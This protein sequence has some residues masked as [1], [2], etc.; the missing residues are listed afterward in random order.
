MHRYGWRTLVAGGLR[1]RAFTSPLRSGRQQQQKIVVGA[2]AT[3]TRDVS[4]S[5]SGT[6]PTRHS[7]KG[8]PPICKDPVE[9]Q[10]LTQQVLETPLG[11]LF[12]QHRN[13]KTNS[14][15][16]SAPKSIPSL[17]QDRDE[18]YAVAYESTQ[19]LEYLLRGYNHQI[20]GSL[21][22]GPNNDDVS[23]EGASA[24]IAT[25]V[26][27]MER[28][29]EEGHTYMKLRYEA[30]SFRAGSTSTNT[31]ALV[32]TVSSL[33][34]RKGQNNIDDE[35]SSSSSSSSSSEEDEDFSFEGDDDE[36]IQ[37]GSSTFGEVE[38][39]FSSVVQHERHL[40]GSQLE[41]HISDFALPGVTTV[42]YDSLLDAMASATE[43][44]LNDNSEKA[45]DPSSI[46]YEIDPEDFYDLTQDAL[47]SH[48]LN[49]QS[50][51]S[52][53]GAFFPYTVPT[54]V[55][56]NASLR[57]IGN[58]CL[59]GSMGGSNQLLID[60]GLACGFG[61][62]NQLTHNTQRLPKRNAASI[63]H[64][65]NI[66]KACFPPSRTRGNMTVTLWHQ[67]SQ[68]GLVTPELVSAI[69]DVHA[70]SNGPEFEFFLE[71]I[72]KC[73][74][75]SPSNG[76]DSEKVVIVP[77]RFARFAKKYQHSKNY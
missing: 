51:A 27:L 29:D 36:E 77:Q 72:N 19:L 2:V 21:F 52:V 46:L 54:M 71:I 60:Q 37:I 64:L 26:S 10:E 11:S 25:M 28:F 69:R 53:K 62:Y 32:D 58:L 40:A 35:E 6:I 57:G 48:E 61:I 15:P 44:L 49:N 3:F 74:S 20:P 70:E 24:T 1:R 4:S 17:S 22:S 56:Y 31:S 76:N 65:L 8:P 41:P 59:A 5:T 68:E 9:L 16:G 34:S 30:N 45:A 67:A 38:D 50:L 18:A 75:S 39:M 63:I 73:Q 42:M 33:S 13:K 14:T 23:I 43:L 55:T 66:I 47:T 7:I 12:C